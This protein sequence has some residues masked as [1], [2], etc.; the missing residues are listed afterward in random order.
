M[1]SKRPD[2]AFPAAPVHRSTGFEQEAPVCA[3]SRGKASG[4]AN[5]ISAADDIWRQ[6]RRVR[7]EWRQRRYLRLLAG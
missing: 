4:G 2:S 1:A 3:Q 5:A 7:Q 6:A